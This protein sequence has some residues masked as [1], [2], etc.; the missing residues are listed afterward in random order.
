MPVILWVEPEVIVRA[1][2]VAVVFV[3]LGHPHHG[4]AIMPYLSCGASGASLRATV[5][6]THKTTAP[7]R[8]GQ[9]IRDA[10]LAKGW[11]RG[12]LAEAIGLQ[13]A[14]NDG[15]SYLDRLEAGKINPT[16]ATLQRIA[17]ALDRPLCVILDPESGGGR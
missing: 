10:R 3:S 13:R 12:D 15:N 16:L 17:D 9:Q 6:S 7:E 5:K 14:K 11:T 8:I 2:V 1:V 4:A